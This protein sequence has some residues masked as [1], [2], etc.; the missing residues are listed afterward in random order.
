[1]ER[2]NI[3]GYEKSGLPVRGAKFTIFQEVARAWHHNW[4]ST[5]MIS[6]LIW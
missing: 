5:I 4:R 3:L 2:D 1:M 6:S